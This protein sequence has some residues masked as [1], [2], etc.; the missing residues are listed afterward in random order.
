MEWLNEPWSSLRYHVLSPCEAYESDWHC[1]KITVLLI[2]IV[3]LLLSLLLE[4]LAISLVSHIVPFPI[5]LLPSLSKAGHAYFRLWQAAICGP[6]AWDQI[7]SSPSRTNRL[8]Q[9]SMEFS[10]SLAPMLSTSVAQNGDVRFHAMVASNVY[11]WKKQLESSIS[12]FPDVSSNTYKNFVLSRPL[13][14]EVCHSGMPFLSSETV[15][16]F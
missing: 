13:G 8:A 9:I 7:P 4:S 14:E 12:Y 2:S 16:M 1:C 15:S 11:F 10:L 3:T 6:A 5:L